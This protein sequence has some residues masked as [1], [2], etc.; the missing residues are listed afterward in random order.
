MTCARS[1]RPT[2]R[3]TPLTG[4]TRAHSAPYGARVPWHSRDSA[5]LVHGPREHGQQNYAR[6]VGTM[7]RGGKMP[8][9]AEKTSTRVSSQR[10]VQTVFLSVRSDFSRTCAQ[11]GRLERLFMNFLDQVLIATPD[12]FA[13]SDAF[14]MYTPAAVG[15]SSFAFFL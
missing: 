14:D 11:S 9:D 13:P 12:A 3:Q 7:L 4:R 8:H 2:D 6:P 15:V 10:A 5:R 1:Q